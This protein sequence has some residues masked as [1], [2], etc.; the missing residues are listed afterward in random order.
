M[1]KP[2]VP[3]PPGEEVKDVFFLGGG[4]M[5]K[6]VFGVTQRAVFFWKRMPFLH[7]IGYHML[8]HFTRFFKKKKFI[9][10]FVNLYP[11][12]ATKCCIPLRHHQML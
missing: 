11:T 6:N 9:I 8:L 5:I 7:K 2:T 3:L 4:V 1:Y 10:F 12:A